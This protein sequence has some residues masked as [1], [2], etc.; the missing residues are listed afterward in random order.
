MVGLP[1]TGS[2]SVEESPTEPRVAIE[3][4]QDEKESADP[5]L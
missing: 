1:T 2:H 4:H 3:S 5:D